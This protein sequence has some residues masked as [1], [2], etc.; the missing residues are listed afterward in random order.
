MN[1]GINAFG[2]GGDGLGI[3]EVAP[4]RPV[5]LPR[6]LGGARVGTRQ[7]DDVMSRVREPSRDRTADQTRSARYQY[8]HD[9]LLVR[10]VDFG[11]SGAVKGNGEI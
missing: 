8:P 9:Q 7:R 1:H 5:A 2:G 6:Q 10:Q 11:R 3:V 4:N